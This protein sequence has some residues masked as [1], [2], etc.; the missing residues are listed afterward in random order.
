MPSLDEEQ[1]ERVYFHLGMAAR[2]GLPKG[3]IQ[4]VFQSA[5][6]I[7]SQLVLDEVVKVLGICD[8]LFDARNPANSQTR[9]TVREIYAGDINRSVVRDI[10]D[11]L[12]RWNEIYLYWVDEL[13]QTLS[14]LNY[15]RTVNQPLRFSRSG[16]SFANLIPGVARTAPASAQFENKRLG[17]SVGFVAYE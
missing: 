5:T 9:F 3:H 12:R 10:I 11:D 16:R 7:S 14:V 1:I 17:G 4:E 13:A 6:N 2:A 8:V 15:R